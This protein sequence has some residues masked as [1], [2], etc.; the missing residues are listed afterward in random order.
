[1]QQCNKDKHPGSFSSA[2]KHV[3][4]ILLVMVTLAIFLKILFIEPI[5][6]L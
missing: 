6:F 3:L 1:M 4:E 2:V 5:S